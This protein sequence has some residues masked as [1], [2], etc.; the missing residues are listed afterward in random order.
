MFPCHKCWKLYKT[1]LF[2]LFCLYVSVRIQ[3]MDGNCNDE[4][5]CNK[6]CDAFVVDT[7]Y[8]L[9][10]KSNLQQFE[11][12]TKFVQRTF[13][14]YKKQQPKTEKNKITAFVIS[15]FVLSH[16]LFYVQFKTIYFFCFAFLCVLFDECNKHFSVSN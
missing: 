5:Q 14:Q 1:G 9:A 7:D 2:S 16:F 3:T 4:Y 12:R 6:L 15:N 11:N 8:I 10:V 13:F